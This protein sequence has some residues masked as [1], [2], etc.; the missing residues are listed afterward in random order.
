MALDVFLK[1]HQ[2]S[3]R[4]KEANSVRQKYF[5]NTSRVSFWGEDMT[6]DVPSDIQDMEDIF[7]G[8]FNISIRRWGKDALWS[9][10]R[11]EFLFVHLS[12]IAFDKSIPVTFFSGAK[13][14][15]VDDARVWSVESA[16]AASIRAVECMS[17]WG[18]TSNLE[19]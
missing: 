15:E 13:V 17:W 2:Y 3:L 9:S 18:L 6:K 16:F 19:Q 10:L 11:T 7:S 5:G 4:V 12:I 8:L 14:G 1:P